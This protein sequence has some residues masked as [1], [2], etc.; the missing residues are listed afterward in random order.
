M[1]PQFIF[2]FTA[3]TIAT[4]VIPFQILSKKVYSNTASLSES[5]L[6]DLSKFG[7]ST[8]ISEENANLL[9]ASIKF[10]VNSERFSRS[11]FY[12]KLSIVFD[13]PP[14]LFNMKIY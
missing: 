2:F 9:K 12:Y 5:E 7:S 3:V 10:I 8:F 11:L 14:L 1:N 4:Y 13:F 6:V